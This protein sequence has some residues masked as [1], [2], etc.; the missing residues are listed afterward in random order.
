[1]FK[2]IKT[3][4]E[5]S[6]KPNSELGF[7]ANF[8]TTMGY[9]SVDKTI[10]VLVESVNRPD[11]TREENAEV[12][13]TEVAS[14]IFG[15]EDFP[16]T[17]DC[18]TWF[19]VYDV[20]ANKISDPIVV[21]DWV[22]TLKNRTIPPA[23]KPYTVGSLQTDLLAYFSPKILPLFHLGNFHRLVPNFEGALLQFFVTNTDDTELSV[24][25][26]VLTNSNLEIMTTL[27]KNQWNSYNALPQITY[28]V[29]DADG[30][31]VN[32]QQTQ[33]MSTRHQKVTLPK[34]DDYFVRINFTKP[35]FKTV[36]NTYDVTVVNGGINKNRIVISEGSSVV[37]INARGLESGDFVKLKLNVGKFLS[38]AEFWITIQ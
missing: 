15:V 21:W 24:F 12:T 18:V 6:L 35:V 28:D 3:K 30:N 14:R 5:G 22:E 19:T 2:I 32:V 25:D 20:E 27:E 33:E 38:F 26:T 17:T 16:Q 11:L 36:S 29:L 9:D 34:A 10:S 4:I 31:V 23:G 7:N 8:R 13:Y 1:M 37:T